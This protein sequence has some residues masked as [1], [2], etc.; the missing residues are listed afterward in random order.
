MPALI[1]DALAFVERK[2][3]RAWSFEADGASGNAERHSGRSCSGWL[4]TGQSPEIWLQASQ[5]TWPLW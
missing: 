3:Y 5:L 2:V 1:D 4:I